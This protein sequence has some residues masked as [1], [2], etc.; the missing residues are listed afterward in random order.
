VGGLPPS[1]V[2]ALLGFLR[3]LAREH[4]LAIA[5]VHHMSKKSRRHLGQALRGS[6]DLWAWSDSAAYL[7]R[8][9]GQVL[10]TVEHR[11]AAAVPPVPLALVVG[12]DGKTPHLACISVTEAVP[13]ATSLSLEERLLHVLR[14]ASEPVSR[15][16]LRRHLGVNNARLGDVLGVLENR[17]AVVRTKLGW[18]L[19][20]SAAEGAVQAPPVSAPPRAP[21][22]DRQPSLPLVL[23]SDPP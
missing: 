16:A 8:T 18:L 4:D 19:A 21:P 13:V 11:A 22:S 17:R 3:R 9:A 1:Y 7:T 5:L 20:P 14:L 15:V 6:S 12:D 2:S 23:D 10:L